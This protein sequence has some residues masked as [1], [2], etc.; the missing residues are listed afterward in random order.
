[1]SR[2]TSQK[3][4]ANADLARSS[5]RDSKSICCKVCI[6]LTPS[7]PRSDRSE[8]LVFADTE[9]ID[10]TQIDSNAVLYVCRTSLCHMSSTLDRETTGGRPSQCTKGLGDVLRGIWSQ[11]TSRAKHTLLRGPI[12]CQRYIVGWIVCVVKLAW[13]CCLKPLTLNECLVIA[14]LIMTLLNVGVYERKTDLVCYAGLL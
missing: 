10:A 13:N 9:M 8:F 2:H 6:D 12:R 14:V 1:M 5:A 4:P 7:Q 3:V 11:N